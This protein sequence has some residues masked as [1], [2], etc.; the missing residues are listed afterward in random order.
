MARNLPRFSVA[1]VCETTDGE[2]NWS[3]FRGRLNL[4]MLKLIAPDLLERTIFTCGPE[5]YMAAVRAM[6]KEAG[7]DMARYH[8]ESF[9]FETLAEFSP[10]Q[11]PLP[12]PFRYR[13]R[14]PKPGPTGSSSPK[15]GR[16]VECA[17]DTNILTAA[18]A[19][20]MRLRR[21]APGPARHLQE[22]AD[23]GNRGEQGRR[24]EQG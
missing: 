17:A 11:P 7:F 15:S 14:P 5:P 1:H 8:E 12:P 3:G 9:N 19:A 6:L 24:V 2:R 20:G 10:R 22:Q 21:P 4:P 23:I 16:V 18:R 13:R